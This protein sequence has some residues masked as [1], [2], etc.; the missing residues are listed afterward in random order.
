M[1]TKITK[2]KCQECGHAA[3]IMGAVKVTWKCNCLVQDGP[4]VCDH[5]NVVE[6]EPSA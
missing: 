3:E 2:V 1:T 6:D 5:V 4:C